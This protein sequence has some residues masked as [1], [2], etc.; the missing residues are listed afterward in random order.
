M[1]MFTGFRLEID[2]A[3][4]DFM[5]DP[6]TEIARQLRSVASRIEIGIRTGSVAD[7]NGNTI[8]HY[9]LEPEFRPL[10]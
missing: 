10:T 5:Q 2:T 7:N 3:N 1:S 9:H 8:G 6:T 4:D